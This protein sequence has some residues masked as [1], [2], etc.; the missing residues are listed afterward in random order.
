MTVDAMTDD[1]DHAQAQLAFSIIESLL[2]HNQVV[3][4]L[5]AMMAQV[6]DQDTTKALTQTPVWAAYLESR[7]RLERTRADVDRFAEF[8]KTLNED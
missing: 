8:M 6:L 7:R 1:L 2:E 4:D 5:I 3:S